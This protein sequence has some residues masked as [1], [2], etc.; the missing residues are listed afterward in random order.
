MAYDYAQAFNESQM[1]ADYNA[2]ECYEREAAMKHCFAQGTLSDLIDL[3]A[4]GVVSR[5]EVLDIINADLEAEI[6][7]AGHNQQE[8]F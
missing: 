5:E 7:E 2:E 3:L 8:L 1:R 4:E 6:A